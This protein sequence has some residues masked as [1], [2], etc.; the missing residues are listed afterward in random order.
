MG[1]FVKSLLVI[2]KFLGKLL[3]SRRGAGQKCQKKCFVICGVGEFDRWNN[4][5]HGELPTSLLSSN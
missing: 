5:N 3:G 4:L 2:L 1:G